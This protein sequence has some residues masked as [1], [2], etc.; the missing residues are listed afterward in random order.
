M[1]EVG[2]DVVP[3]NVNENL[4]NIHTI[5]RGLEMVVMTGQ[6]C[7]E[8]ALCSLLCSSHIILESVQLKDLNKHTKLI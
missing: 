5:I 8:R 6:K 7:E 2:P 3:E 4:H 1:T